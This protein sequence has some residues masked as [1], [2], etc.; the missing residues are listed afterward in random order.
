MAAHYS[1]AAN[2]FP[3]PVK[4]ALGISKVAFAPDPNRRLLAVSTW[5][6][7][8]RVYDV[9]NPHTPIDVRT[10]MHSKSVLCCTFVDT[11]KLV[12]GGLDE[13]V[14]VCDLESAR[15]RYLVWEGVGGGF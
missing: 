5:D 9:A 7:F 12:S 14:K 15:G 1:A 4:S 3:I 8:V 6:G 11:S 2:E 13:V 10:Y